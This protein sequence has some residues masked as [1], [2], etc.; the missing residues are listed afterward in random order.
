MASNTAKT[1]FFISLGRKC[2]QYMGNFNS[3]YTLF[4]LR[5]SLDNTYLNGFEKSVLLKM[6]FVWSIG[7]P[8]NMAM[9]SLQNILSPQETLQE[10]S[11]SLTSM[12][13]YVSVSYHLLLELF[14][15]IILY[16]YY[17]KFVEIRHINLF[18]QILF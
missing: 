13:P 10:L 2:H 6:L 1:H 9:V 7:N 4:F 17:L 11:D 14:L 15:S 12:L 3:Y 8:I 18:I 16:T 5:I